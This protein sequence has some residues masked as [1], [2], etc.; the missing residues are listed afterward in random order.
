MT[1]KFVKF[2]KKLNIVKYIL[3]LVEALVG[4]V[5]AHRLHKE[6]MVSGISIEESIK[7][8]NRRW[9]DVK[10]CAQESPIFIF[11][12]GWRSGSTLLQRLLMSKESLLV[13]GEPFSQAG[14]IEHL[15]RPILAINHR[16]P[17]EEWFVEYFDS[18]KMCE[19]WVANLY[20]SIQSLL[21]ANLQYLRT[22]FAPPFSS[23]VVEQ[24]WGVKEV[25]LTIDHA[26]YLR[27]IFPK[28]KFLFLYRNPYKSYASY[29]PSRNW[30]KEWP[31]KPVFTPY[32]FAQ[33]WRQLTEGFLCGFEDVDGLL[34]KYEDLCEGRLDIDA[35]SKYLDIEIDASLLRTPVGSSNVKI[36]DIPTLELFIVKS[37][38]EPLASSLGYRID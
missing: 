37:V 20:P 14:L 31:D 17:N 11:S 1:F 8:I 15:S 5:D 16:W 3:S 35:L 34:I 24:R 21:D 4:T 22:L 36:Y 38:V 26:F 19:L 29:R 28:A 25:R 6:L 32:R 23:H 13:W 2:L 18:K 9:P 30:Y 12:A 10:S 7:I 27:W 33:H